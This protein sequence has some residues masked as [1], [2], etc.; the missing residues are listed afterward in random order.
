MTEP[1]TIT[2]KLLRRAQGNIDKVINENNLSK[3]EKTL[4]EGQKLILSFIEDDH[5]K[6]TE[7]YADF[8]ERKEVRAKREKYTTPVVVAIVIAFITQAVYFWADIFPKLQ[9]LP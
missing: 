8:V 2:G 5:R 4:L 1:E 6:T 9:N 7:M 3:A